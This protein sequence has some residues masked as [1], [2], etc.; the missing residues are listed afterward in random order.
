MQRSY[1][2]DEEGP[3]KALVIELPLVAPGWINFRVVDPYADEETVFIRGILERK[4]FISAI[5]QEIFRYFKEEFVI[6]D[7]IGY[8]PPGALET[9]IMEY[10]GPEKFREEYGERPRPFEQEP[11]F[12]EKILADPWFVHQS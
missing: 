7:F 1:P 5:K 11:H 6:E 3:D 9:A 12:G 10:L 4:Q 8:I 2:I